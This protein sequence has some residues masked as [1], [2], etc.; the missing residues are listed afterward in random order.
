MIAIAFCYSNQVFAQNIDVMMVYTDGVNARY[1][2]SPSTRFQHLIAVSNQIYIDSEVPLQLNLVSTQK[3]NYADQGSANIALNQ[4]TQNAGVFSNIESLRSSTGADMVILYRTYQS[5]HGSCGLAWVNQ[6][7]NGDFSQNY[8]KRYMYAHIGIDA[9]PEFTT[10]H[11]LG[12]NMGLKHSRKQDGSGGAFPFALG[13][14][15]DGLFTDTMAYASSFGVDYWSGPIWKFSNPNLTCRG[16]PCGVDR[17]DP[18]NGADA[19]YA[20]SITGPQIANYYGA[21]NIDLATLQSNLDAAKLSLT[22][23]QTDVT[24][25]TKNVATLTANVNA[26]KL[27]VTAAS[28]LVNTTNSNIIKIKS[29]LVKAQSTLS[30]SNSNLK[31]LQTKL[32]NTPEKQKAAIQSQIDKLN[33]QII[34]QTSIIDN[35]TSQI[36]STTTALKTVTDALNSK[37]SDLTSLQNQLKEAQTA[38]LTAKTSLSTAQTNYNTALT[39]YNNGNT[40]K[41]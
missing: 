30:A 37:V 11:E 40:G 28:K 27:L 39:A 16:V 7:N 10:A 17:T 20:I 3:V 38:L 14:G 29:S 4:I 1:S 6:G 24:N 8:S 12:H 36:E 13:Y 22:N 25:K 2:F 32:I 26:M 33:T 41:A 9:C 35:L 34:T 21:K 19:A 5:S 31:N 18:V 15:V 23:A